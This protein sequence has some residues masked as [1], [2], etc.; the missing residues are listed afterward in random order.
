MLAELRTGERDDL[1]FPEDVSV[2]NQGGATRKRVR[3]QATSRSKKNEHETHRDQPENV[4]R[5]F[6]VVGNIEHFVFPHGSLSLSLS[7]S[8]SRIDQTPSL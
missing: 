3:Y 2:R 4:A 7:P 6:D 5:L 1:S 8:F